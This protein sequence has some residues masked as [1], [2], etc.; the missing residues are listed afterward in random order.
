M[1]IRSIGILAT[2]RVA[3][4]D[5][6]YPQLFLREFDH[7]GVLWPFVHTF[8]QSANDERYST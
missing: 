4:R 1:R 3:Y 7:D 8:C 5:D 6:R 2:F